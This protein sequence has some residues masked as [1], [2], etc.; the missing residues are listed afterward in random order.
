MLILIAQVSV[1][2]ALKQSN[3]SGV[4]FHRLA[5]R[6]TTTTGPVN[7]RNYLLPYHLTS[8]TATVWLCTKRTINWNLWLGIVGPLGSVMLV[9]VVGHYWP[10]AA[11]RPTYINKSHQINWQFDIACLSR[12]YRRLH[13]TK[14]QTACVRF[15]VYVHKKYRTNWPSQVWARPT[16]PIV[17]I[18]HWA[19]NWAWCTGSPPAGLFELCAWWYPAITFRQVC[20]YPPSQ[21][22]SLLIAQC[23]PVSTKLYCLV[24]EAH[25]S[26]PKAVTWSGLAEIRTR[27][28]L[29]HK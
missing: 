4:T 13:L 23:K 8:F 18:E 16:S 12:S 28:L 3:Q 2:L 1:K 7:I 22:T 9:L 21:R 26:L 5:Y 19:R 20:S 10:I 6:P 15:V 14:A 25:A 27:D 17:V 11:N 24:A 29:G